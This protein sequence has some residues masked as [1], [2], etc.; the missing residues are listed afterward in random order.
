MRD[1]APFNMADLE[2]LDALFMS[3]AER[4]VSLCDVVAGERAPNCGP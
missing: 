3:K 1:N 4:V 2:D